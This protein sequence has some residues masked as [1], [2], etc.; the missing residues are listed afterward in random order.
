[1]VVSVNKTVYEL[2]S[3]H[4][5]SSTLVTGLETLTC[6]LNQ[7]TSQISKQTE[8]Q[9]KQQPKK[10][11]VFVSLEQPLGQYLNS[12]TQRTTT[13]LKQSSVISFNVAK[14][15]NFQLS[16]NS[17]K[18]YSAYL[19]EELKPC[20]DSLAN[21]DLSVVLVGQ[22]FSS[23]L[24][25]YTAMYYPESFAGA[26][27]VGGSFYWKP[28]TETKWEWLTQLFVDSSTCPNPIY[29][30]SSLKETIISP[31]EVPSTLVA[32]QHFYNI[33]KAKGCT[34]HLKEYDASPPSPAFIAEMQ[35]GC[36]WLYEQIEL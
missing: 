35:Q 31:R 20:L 32:N 18:A 10:Q 17:I 12:L 26:L 21:Q 3:Q 2:Y 34:V 28:V 6:N 1:M 25:A 19:V 22:Q 11:L 16:A 30:M 9:V 36:E 29:L 24:A 14:Q 4:L 7:E 27:S 23:I 13:A 5:K 8:Q 15:Y 33:A